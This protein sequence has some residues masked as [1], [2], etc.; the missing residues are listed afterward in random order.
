MQG[1]PL[2]FSQFPR[3]WRELLQRHRDIDDGVGELAKERGLTGQQVDPV[4]TVLPIH[5]KRCERTVLPCYPLNETAGDVEA[6]LRVRITSELHGWRESGV[7][8]GRL[9]HN[10]VQYRVDVEKRGGGVRVQIV[11][12]IG[13]SGHAKSNRWSGGGR[14]RR[15]VQRA[16]GDCHAT[17]V[18]IV[19]EIL[20]G[21][22]DN[23]QTVS[24]RIEVTTKRGFRKQDCERVYKGRLGILCVDRIH[25]AP[26]A[27]AVKLP[28]LH[29]EV[30]ANECGV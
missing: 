6:N 18:H 28:I 30:N 1:L 2:D 11:V 12:G 25:P 8:G 7:V 9:E 15:V 17:C 21:V 16:V 19:P 24:R 3:A 5:Y 23:P 29:S 22:T 10:L 14:H 20:A 26:I 4:E 13:R 27:D